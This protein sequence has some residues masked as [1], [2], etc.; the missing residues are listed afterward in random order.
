MTNDLFP[1]FECSTLAIWKPSLTL[2]PMCRNTYQELCTNIKGSEYAR[3]EK[4]VRH[5]IE[6]PGHDYSVLLGHLRFDIQLFSHL[7]LLRALLSDQF[8]IVD[9]C[10][11]GPK[12]TDHSGFCVCTLERDIDEIILREMYCSTMVAVEWLRWKEKVGSVIMCYKF[13]RTLMD[14]QITCNVYREESN[15]QSSSDST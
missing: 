11:H 14:W 2:C 12:L 3:L 5:G 13:K 10:S 4:R 6:T 8:E 1:C 9:D 7:E 15:V